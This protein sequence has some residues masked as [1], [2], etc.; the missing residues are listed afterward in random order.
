MSGG[1]TKWMIVSPEV[2]AGWMASAGAIA[3][4]IWMWVLK[5]R[6]NVAE[7]R[8][9]VAEAGAATA[10]AEASD[11]VFTLVTNRLTAM[12]KELIE[13]RADLVEKNRR[14]HAM[15]LHIV[16]LEHALRKAGIE[17]PPIRNY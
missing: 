6:K 11:S 16:D 1:P 10:R 5:Q 14:M 4:G 13:L 8:A 17:P 9:E 7:T 2:I 15:E 12:E 3:G